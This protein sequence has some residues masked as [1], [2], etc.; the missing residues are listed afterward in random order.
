LGGE[1]KYLV[2]VPCTCL[3]GIGEL[4]DS[5]TL[6]WEGHH[7]WE[8][9][10]P[11][12]FA[13][14][15]VNGCISLLQLRRQNTIDR[16]AH[17]TEIYFCTVLELEVQGQDAS[18]MG[19]GKGLSSWLVDG[20]FLAVTLLRGETERESAQ[21]SHPGLGLGHGFNTASCYKH[22]N[23]RGNALHCACRDP[24]SFG[25]S[26]APVSAPKL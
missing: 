24:C 5:Q 9:Q 16:A 8:C 10:L 13:A 22:I 3:P 11:A 18:T 12:L 6:V 21:V 14:S 4:G 17:T 25:L 1:H 15:S 19:S 20:C 2:I 23:Q 7:P 26:S